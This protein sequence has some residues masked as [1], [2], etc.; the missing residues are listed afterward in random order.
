MAR[1]IL[2]AGWVI[3]FAACPAKADDAV[4]PARAGTS[5]KTEN[6]LPASHV[7]AIEALIRLTRDQDPNVRRTA[8][9]ALGTIG[10]ETPSLARAVAAGVKD[11]DVTV[12]NAAYETLSRAISDGA[13]KVAI[14]LSAVQDENETIALRAAEDLGKLGKEAVPHLTQALEDENLQMLVIHTL[15][16]IGTDAIDA[17]SDLT[18]LLKN[19][20][21]EVRIAVAESLSSICRR[22]NANSESARR[23]ALM[24]DFAS[25]RGSRSSTSSGAIRRF[26]DALIIR[27]DED[28]D[29]KLG[30]KEWSGSG[31]PNLDASADQD[32]DGAISRSELAT[33]YKARSRGGRGSG[34]VSG[35]ITGGAVPVPMR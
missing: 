33:W 24:R 9:G 8:F 11:D 27:F 35:A 3:V 5:E 4:D 18:P 29:G 31:L 13:E 22:S 34:G 21:P 25:R 32:D 17:I 23:E 19:E 16:S 26:T 20:N 12:R 7:Q 14:L 15:Q 10:R 6:Q 30:A 2:I 1:S 28:R